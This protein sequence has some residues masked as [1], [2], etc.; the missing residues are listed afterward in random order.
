M[1]GATCRILRTFCCGSWRLCRAICRALCSGELCN[2]RYVCR[3]FVLVIHL[4]LVANVAVKRPFMLQPISHEEHLRAGAMWILVAVTLSVY[5]ATSLSDPGFATKR[6]FSAKPASCCLLGLCCAPVATLAAA[7]QAL[8]E[9]AGEDDGSKAKELTP[10][11]EIKDPDAEPSST[12]ADTEFSEAG[13]V[14][15]IQKRRGGAQEDCDEELGAV[16][17]QC[18]QELHWCVHCRIYQPLRMKHCRDCQRCVR[19]HDHHCPWLGNCVGENNRV[20]FYWFLVFQLTELIVF[21][22]EGVQG[23]SIFRPSAV[24]IV[25]LLVIALF[26]IMVFCLLMFHA[27]LALSNLTTWE[28]V[29]WKRITYLKGLKEANGSPFTRGVLGNVAVYCGGPHWC[30]VP[31]RRLASLRYDEEGAIIWELGEQRMPCLLYFCVE[32]LGC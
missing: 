23:I 11:T 14:G 7:W 19:T 1:P 17:S 18:G 16:P 25:G 3:G 31:L 8:A 6:E 21:F 28:Q 12:D 22:F 26:G 9:L 27:F 30:P 20:L 13:E 4:A 24:L 5:L 29:S 15:G 2:E 10:V 32:W